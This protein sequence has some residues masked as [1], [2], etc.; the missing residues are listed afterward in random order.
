MVKWK[1]IVNL[2]KLQ[3]S[4]GLHLANKL[5]AAHISWFRKKMNVR[6]AAQ[7][8][9]ES[10]ASSLDFARKEGLDGFE[11]CE[12]TIKFIK[13]FDQLFDVLNSRN[14]KAFGYKAPLQTR[15]FDDV[16]VLFSQAREYI[17]GLR[18][19][20]NGPKILSGN[21]KTGFMGF[22]LAIESFQ[23]ASFN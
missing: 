6:L 15:N 1:Y 16:C 11:D 3:E 12:E 22:L 21:R 23:G 9:S 20:R 13:V 2:H 10:V 17:L 14:L 4:E 5:R 8:L 7:T 19:M 18:Q